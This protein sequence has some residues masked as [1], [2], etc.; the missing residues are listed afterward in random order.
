MKTLYINNFGIVISCGLL[1]LLVTWKMGSI[2][3]PSLHCYP[4]YLICCLELSD[5]GAHPD[6]GEFW[7]SLLDMDGALALSTLCCHSRMFVSTSILPIAA[8]F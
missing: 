4:T 3:I 2:E 8:Y 7:W 1:R 6:L 5:L